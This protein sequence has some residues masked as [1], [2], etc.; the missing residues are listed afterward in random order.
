MK[1]LNI[2]EKIDSIL[3]IHNVEVSYSIFKKNV[4]RDIVKFIG[5]N[6]RRRKYKTPGYTCHCGKFNKPMKICNCK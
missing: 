5:E 6:Y 2:S 4:I 1:R 3:T